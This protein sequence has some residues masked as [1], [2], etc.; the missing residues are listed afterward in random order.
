[1]RLVILLA[2]LLFSTL[3]VR[4]A[5]PVPAAPAASVCGPP[6]TLAVTTATANTQLPW[7]NTNCANITLLNDGANEVFVVTG[8]TGVVATTAGIPIPSGYS[9]S[10]QTNATYVAAITAT[11]T[12]TLRII[13]ATG[14][15]RYGQGSGGFTPAVPSIAFTMLAGGAISSTVPGSG[16]FAVA[17]PSGLTSATWGAG[18]SGASTVTGF[19]ITGLTWSATFSTPASPCTGT[20]SVTGTGSNTASATSPATVITGAG[21]NA[22]LIAS[23]S[24]FLINS[25]SKLLIQ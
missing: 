20:L 3:Q 5:P 9:I 1:M 7:S 23:G 6:V 25:G 22:L 10:I 12:S 14:S 21:G 8:D 17:A 16:S 13:Q 19:S 15:L 24:A 11:S 2:G 18:C 4:A